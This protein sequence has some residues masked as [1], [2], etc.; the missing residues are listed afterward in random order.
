MIHSEKE[1]LFRLL[2]A[3]AVGMSLTE[4]CMMLPGASVSGIYFGHPR[5]R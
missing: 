4:S 3:T 5:A 1:K 2:D